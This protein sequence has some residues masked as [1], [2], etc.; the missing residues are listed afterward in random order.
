MAKQE[1]TDK[2][3]IVS[4]S[5]HLMEPATSRRVMCEV[6]IGCTLPIIA[7]IIFFRLEAV[8]ILTTCIVSAIATEWIFNDIRKKPQTALD[9]SAVVAAIILGLSLPPTLPLWTAAIG[10]IAAI[11]IGKMVFGGLGCNIFNPA[12]VGRAFLMACF[13]LL[14]TTW[15]PTELNKVEGVQND[16]VSTAT[17]LSYMKKPIKDHNDEDMD[18]NLK[19]DAT[20]LVE[21]IDMSDLFYGNVS[22]SLGETSALAWLI[23]GVF[24]LWRK[25][26]TWHI[27]VAVLGSAGAISTAAYLLN[28]N[29]YVGP[30]TH[31][32]SG[33][34]MM[35]AFFIATDLVTC[36]LSKLGRFI[37]GLG[38]GSL[39]MLI[40]LKGTLPEG[41]VFSVL[42]M[43]S[44][45]PLLDRWTRPTPVGGHVNVN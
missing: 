22:G 38:V 1:K 32:F 9:G 16:A 26:I 5:P 25:T 44:M 21:Q 34:L 19:V 8:L 40:R 42:L 39:V 18:D 43:N 10:S 41:V 4:S 15:T 3:L 27:P 6:M 20:D 24:L 45:T 33:G 30:L 37:F 2:V 29:V 35:C 14:L 36:P 31:L 13:G 7:S 28:E 11:G 23:G 17:P 12:M